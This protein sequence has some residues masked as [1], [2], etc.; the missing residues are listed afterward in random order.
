MLLTSSLVSAK[1]HKLCPV[2]V[3][4]LGTVIVNPFYLVMVTNTPVK[5]G[6]IQM[7]EHNLFHACIFVI[8]AK[9]SSMTVWWV[10]VLGWGR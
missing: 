7:Q 3:H 6:E 5:A 2:L 10:A 4:C 8:Y 9:Q 1:V